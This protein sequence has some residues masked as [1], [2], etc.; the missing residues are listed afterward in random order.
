M[1]SLTL[2]ETQRQ[3]NFC[4]APRTVA[5]CRQGATRGRAAVVSSQRGS[6]L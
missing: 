3:R 6:R 4:A 1:I 2:P 5:T